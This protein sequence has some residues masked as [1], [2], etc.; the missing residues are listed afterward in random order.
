MHRIHTAGNASDRPETSYI[1]KIKH[2][3]TEEIER[4]KEQLDWHDLSAS[5][6]TCDWSISFIERFEKYIDIRWLFYNYQ[7]WQACFGSLGD[8]DIDLL[9][10]DKE[11]ISRVEYDRKE[12]AEIRQEIDEQEDP[13]EASHYLIPDCHTYDYFLEKNRDKFPDAK[14]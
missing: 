5:G 10:I 13:V 9:L 3:A 1:H 6:S 7:A 4:H 11:F 14:P 8:E 12:K 2:W